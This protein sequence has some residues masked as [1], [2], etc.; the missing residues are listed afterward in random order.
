M[1]ARRAL[2]RL[3]RIDRPDV[4]HIA[5]EGPLG[6]SALKAALQ[7]HLPVS[8]DFRTNFHAYSSHY[9]VGF[10]HRPIMAYLRRF[11][12]LAHL[13]LVPTEALREA[14]EDAGF[15]GLR[16][17]G[18]GVDTARFS[19]QRRSEALRAT[20]GVDEQDL[21]VCC[22]G[23]LAAEKN[24]PLAIRAWRAIRASQP[25]ARL[26]FVGDGPLRAQ[27]Q[28]ECPDAIFV[29][30]KDGEDLAACYAS[31]DLFLFPSLT[32]TFGNVTLEAMACGLPVVAFDCA[33]AQALITSG[34]NGLRVPRG[35]VSAFVEAAVLLAGEP[36]RRQA[37]GRRARERAERS[38]WSTVTAGFL[39]ELER[40]IA[41]H[42]AIEGARGQA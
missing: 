42:R 4:V 33:A 9:G 6:W 7:L 35:D 32:E 8:S 26:L 40:L 23:R 41:S 37:V 3:W 10:L 17:V 38:G 27:L 30:R 25:S 11:H 1:P 15:R 16:V 12:T 18:R 2:L 5:T 19:P 31:S 13:T 24:L 29:G 36:P 21:V 20:W 39:S 28:S 34:V 22:V 14:L